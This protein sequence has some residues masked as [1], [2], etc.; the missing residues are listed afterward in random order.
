MKKRARMKTSINIELDRPEESAAVLKAIASL[1]RLKILKS[2]MSS[3]PALN[4][5]ELAEKFGLPITTASLHVRT[6]AKAGLVYVKEIK[7]PRKGTQK[8]CIPLVETIHMDLKDSKSDENRTRS[9][10]YSMP[11]GNYFDCNITRPCGMA[12]KKPT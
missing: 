12:G 10:H 9:I 2:I 3:S 1:E 8:I 11:L 4:V 7:G 6:L 5:K